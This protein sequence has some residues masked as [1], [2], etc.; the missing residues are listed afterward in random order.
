MT[1][2]SFLNTVH[3]CADCGAPAGDICADQCP[4]AI[5][6]ELEAETQYDPPCCPDPLTAAAALCACWGLGSG[7]AA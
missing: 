5:A 7:V 6:L 4:S 2:W 3:R 1:A